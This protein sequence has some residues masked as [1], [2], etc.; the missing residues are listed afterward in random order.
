MKFSRKTLGIPY[1][2]FLL[3][4]VAA[5]L[6]VLF[7]YAFTNGQGQFT[8]KN[9]T[10]FF[11]DPNTLGTLFYSF[12]I[13]VVTTVTLIRF[14]QYNKAAE[15]FTAGEYEQS[16]AAF[17]AM[18]DYQDARARVFMSAVE[19]YKAKRY[20]EALPYFVWLDGYPDHGYFLQHC[21]ERLAAGK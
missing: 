11:T 6:L 17:Q 15:F 19:L 20:E 14:R 16:A 9:L 3:L 7:Y 13:A 10:D 8:V 18:G 12:M 5:P 2:A 1:A 4:F 21:Q